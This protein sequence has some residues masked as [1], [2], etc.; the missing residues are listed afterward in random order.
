MTPD[1]AAGPPIPTPPVP[2]S[3][4][5]WQSAAAGYAVA[6]I[7]LLVG[8]PLFLCMPPWNDVTLHDM[9]VRNILRGG[10]HY[11]DIFDTNLPGIDWAMVVMRSTC[12]WSYEVLRAWDLAIIGA[13]VVLLAGWVR[14]C[15]GSAAAVAWFVAAATLF[16]PFTTEFCHCQR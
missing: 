7:A 2:G 6:A 8:V 3:W 10:V 4:R 12:G 5:P 13:E 16:Y 11:R 9:A 1:P 15:G 14:K